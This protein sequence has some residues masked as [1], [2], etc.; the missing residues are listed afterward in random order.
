MKFGLGYANT[1]PFTDPGPARDLVQAAEE[2]GFESVWTVEHVIWPH[3]YDSEYPYHPSGKMPGN[4]S[5]PIP[6]P[7]IWLTWVAAATT[8]LRLGTGVVILPQRNPLVLAKELA[9]LDHLSGGRVEFGMGVGWLVEE[10]E[11][12]GVEFS[13]RGRRAN[14]MIEAMRVAWR[15]DEA[16]YRGDVVQFEA[17][18]LNPKPA[19]GAIPVHVGGHSRAAAR[20]AARLGDGFFPGPGSLDGL[21]QALTALRE[22]C[23]A[24]RRDAAEVE[25][26]A[27]FP[28]RFMRSPGEAVA[29]LAALGVDRVIVPVYEVARPSLD[30]GMAAF[31]DATR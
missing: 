8:T 21:E 18:A 20:R 22:E 2:V 9:T 7:L 24:A 26:S 27:A 12:L 19:N 29:A 1:I 6:D 23:A 25:V 3:S 13:G 14:E 17:V 15:D 4:P 31:A 5:I 30:E 16:T 10:F 11:A 28:G